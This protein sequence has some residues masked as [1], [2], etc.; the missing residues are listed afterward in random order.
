[1]NYKTLLSAATLG[2]ATFLPFATASAV[3][4]SSVTIVDS[5]QYDATS[6][7]SH[8]VCLGDLEVKHDSDAILST[9]SVAPG[10]YELAVAGDGSSCGDSEGDW[11]T[12]E[13]TVADVASQSIGFSWPMWVGDAQE[14]TLPTWQHSNDP[15]CV[16]DGQGRVVLRNYSSV[17]IN[18]ATVS[19]G[20]QLPKAGDEVLIGDVAVGDEGTAVTAPPSYPAPDALGA[21]DAWAE[22][23]WE[24]PV[25]WAFDALPVTA[26][27][28]TIVYAYGGGDGAI[29]LVYEQVPNDSCDTTTTT[30]APATTSAPTTVPDRVGADNVAQAAQPVAATPAY[31]G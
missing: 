8:T 24:S 19:I 31:T 27:V 30:E 11:I 23:E 20:L 18:D 1:M 3:T 7:L 21:F 25:E 4:T 29:G 12:A 15:S 17:D 14:P 26:N 10:T 22:G 13:V 16:A 2:V 9:V 5:Y 28:T 6:L